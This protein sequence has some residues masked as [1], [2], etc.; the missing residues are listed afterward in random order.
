MR[1]AA[2]ESEEAFQGAGSGP[3]LEVWRIVYD[4]LTLEPRRAVPR[5]AVFPLP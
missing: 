3:G 1:K 2:A 4:P 5:E